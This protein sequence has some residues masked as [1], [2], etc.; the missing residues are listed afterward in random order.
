MEKMIKAYDFVWFRG[1]NGVFFGR[2]EGDFTLFRVKYAP[3]LYKNEW[4]WAS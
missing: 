3:I 4:I 2:I 1:D